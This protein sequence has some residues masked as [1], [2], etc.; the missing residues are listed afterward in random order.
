MATQITMK[1]PSTGIIKTGFYGFSWT[2]LFFGFFPA[3]F[4]GDFLTFIGGFVIW[5]ILVFATWGVGA[6]IAMIVWAFL[7]NSY[8]TKKLLERGYIFSATDWEILNASKALGV[9]V[10][11]RASDA[12]HSVVTSVNRNENSRDSQIKIAV[13]KKILSNDAYKI[14]LVKKYKIENNDVLKKYVFNETLYE[15]VELALEAAHTFEMEND[16]QADHKFQRWTVTDALHAIEAAGYQIN[17][18]ASGY[19]LSKNTTTRYIK[20]DQELISFAKNIGG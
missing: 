16:K 3:L 17:S 19:Q 2:T 7:Y 18:S 6:I 9:Q 11:P 4:R 10:K 12:E 1:H 14:Y 13:E 8:Y 20:D 5:C 15:T